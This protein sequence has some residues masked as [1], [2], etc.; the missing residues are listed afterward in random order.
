MPKFR[1]KPV[2]IE[3]EQFRPGVAPL[4]F[5][6]RMACMLDDE[7]WYVVTAHGQRTPIVDGDWIIPEPDSRGFYPCKSDIFKA[8]YDP[9]D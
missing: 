5:E 8:T 9:A 2:V 4:P 3:A 1:K 6:A 7:G